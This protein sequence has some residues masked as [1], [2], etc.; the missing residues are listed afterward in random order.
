MFSWLYDT[1]FPL[2][3]DFI[4]IIVAIAET[5]PTWW[6][7]SID[8]MISTDAT[9][10]ILRYNNYFTQ[11]GFIAPSALFLEI[12]LGI[13]NWPIIGSIFYNLLNFFF[14]TFLFFAPNAPLWIALPIALGCWSI[15]LIG[16]K[17]FLS[18]VKELL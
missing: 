16:L 6:F 7:E 4:G 8:H 15:A 13:L 5:S 12:P 11:M 1:L 2:V 3:G 17:W 14:S 10:I 18:I 9:S